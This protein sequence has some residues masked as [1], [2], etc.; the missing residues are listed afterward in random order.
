M[1]KIK[2]SMHF[3]SLVFKESFQVISLQGFGGSLV[4]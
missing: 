1:R 4:L 3:N 2:T